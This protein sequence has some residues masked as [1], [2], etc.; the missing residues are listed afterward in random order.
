MG[1]VECK[2]LGKEFTDP[3]HEYK[4][5]RDTLCKVHVV[6][7][8]E[9]IP[10]YDESLEGEVIE[11]T[12]LD[13]LGMYFLG[14]YRIGAPCVVPGYVPTQRSGVDALLHEKTGVFVWSQALDFRGVADQSSENETDTCE[15]AGSSTTL[16]DS[17]CVFHYTSEVNFRRLARYGQMADAAAELLGSDGP[18]G[19]GLH[20]CR[21]PP[22]FWE[23]RGEILVNV[24][25]P[26]RAVVEQCGGNAQLGA[27]DRHNTSLRRRLVQEHGTTS[28]GF[29][30]PVLC[31]AKHLVSPLW[32]GGRN[33][34]DE[35]QPQWRDISVLSIPLE[36]Q[37]ERAWMATDAQIGV[38]K[39]R[40]EWC[41]AGEA[42]GAETLAAISRLETAL[43]DS[44]DRLELMDP[45]GWWPRQRE[46]TGT[47]ERP[48]Y[49]EF[50]SV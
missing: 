19:S 25:W 1:H 22:H 8:A 12:C 35:P 15:S 4:C 11:E 45:T 16:S 38:L 23:S 18:F 10:A 36:Q 30:V 24:R 14:P 31:L 34:W 29:C 28:V 3:R 40:M 21:K 13:E 37:R 7:S 46:G 6:A 50:P 9:A 48:D 42:S 49:E 2:Q 20:S 44:A 26:R 39:L 33:R 43:R 41:R 47:M 32:P 27:L 17:A 5:S